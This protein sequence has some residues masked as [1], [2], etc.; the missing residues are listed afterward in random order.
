MC[1]MAGFFASEGEIDCVRFPSAL[2][3]LKNR[4]PDDEGYA[5]EQD[6]QLRLFKGDDTVAGWRHLPPVGQLSRAQWAF[7]HRRLAIIDLSANAHQPFV[8]DDQ[9]HVL[10]FNG[11]IFNYVELR[12]ELRDLGHEFR[13]E[14]DTEVVLHAWI[15]W[16]TS[17]FNR[18]NG[19]WALAIIDR[20]ELQMTLCRDRFGIKPLFYSL[21]NQVLSFASEIKFLKHWH[22]DRLTLNT[23]AA[24]RYLVH[25][26]VSHSSETFFEE[27]QE[28]EPGN[29]LHFGK[30]GLKIGRY[31]EFEPRV[32]T[33]CS[34][35]EALEQFTVLFEDSLRLRMRSDVE[36]GSLLSGGLDSNTIVCTLQHL[37]YIRPGRFKTFSAVFEEAQFSEIDYIRETLKQVAV[38]PLFVSPRPEEFLE[39]F[40]ALLHHIEEPFRSLSIYLQYRLYRK[41]RKDTNVRVVLNGQG[42]DEL[43]GGY[44]MHY[45]VLF[46]ELIRK[47]RLGQLAHEMRLHRANRGGSWKSLIRQIASH[48]LKGSSDGE[49]LNRQLF[50]EVRVASLREYLRYDDRNSMAFGI[51]ARVPFLDY[52]LVEFAFGLPSEF[53]IKDFRNKA[54]VRDYAAGKVPAGILERK[55]KM[56]FVS[57]QEI[58]QR[59]QLLPLFEQVYR[60]PNARL[61]ELS[62]VQMRKKFQD[63][64]DRKNNAWS[65]AWRYLCMDQWLRQWAPQ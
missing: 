56:G 55:D 23:E 18:F 3:L 24:K 31:W 29:W 17:A 26:L 28:L 46:A 39:D 52:R 61:A 19:M 32:V 7:G 2:H 25:G 40:H 16:G 43:F 45:P 49:L 9:R 34:A 47:G 41:I 51:E 30:T 1:G 57:P 13:S 60:R 15:E 4:G 8:S 10:V 64:V 63:Y 59:E 12:A 42:A 53:K 33:R 22:H 35:A 65:D 6:G 38:E 20:Q 21:E 14:S 36:V 5:A 27:V 50:H 54:I 37:D 48:L 62:T 11:E 44:A 58:W